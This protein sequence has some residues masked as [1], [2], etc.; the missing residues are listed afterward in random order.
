MPKK[1][2]FVSS[3]VLLKDLNKHIEYGKPFS[4]IRLGDGCS[5]TILHY[6]YIDKLREICRKE[7]LNLF[8]YTV[9][10]KN[11]LKKK[12]YGRYTE[13][14]FK[15]ICNRVIRYCNQANYIDRLDSF[16]E[17][18]NYGKNE[19]NVEMAIVN[20]WQYVWKTFGINND[21]YT[22]MFANL[23]SIVKDEYNLFD[24]ASGKNIFCISNE[25][26][27]VK[28]FSN[29]SNAKKV[30]SYILPKSHYDQPLHFKKV[31]RL[32]R[33]NINEY[34]LFL[35][36]AGFLG[37]IYLGLVKQLG[38]CSFD[39]GRCFNFWADGGFKPRKI[40][41]EGIFDVDKETKMMY[42]RK[43]KK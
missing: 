10:L 8:K 26:N 34:D 5:L 36:G 28:A 40:D 17:Y 23:Y 19:K 13:E 15:K 39:T 37:K 43:G 3:E 42:E 20:N 1:Y 27:G 24:V 16:Y 29:F 35:I 41:K 4:N 21:N 22:S 6:L 11:G 33:R 18:S 7:G 12:R 9:K 2:K 14:E 38:G 25:P 31:C 32:I 30:D